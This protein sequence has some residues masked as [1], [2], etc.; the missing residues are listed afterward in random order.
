MTGEAEAQFREVGGDADGGPPRRIAVRHIR[1]AAAGAPGLFWLS[2]FKSDMASTKATAVAAYAR[3]HGLA[4]TL[5]DYSGHGLSSGRFEDGTIGQ[6]LEEACAVFRDMTTGPQV[7]IGSSM[8]GHIALLLLRRLIAEHPDHARRLAALV[9]IAPA[10]D[11][12]E[13]LIWKGMGEAARR[14][15]MDKGI[16]YRPSDYGEPYAITR[17][18]IEDGRRHL[19]SGRPF[20]PGRPVYILQ[21]ARDPDVPLAHVEALVGFLRGGWA[22]LEVVADGEHRLSRPEDLARLFSLVGRA[23]ADARR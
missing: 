7:V 22:H 13:A 15:V 4:A 1:A 14:A 23:V 2:G 5:F 6:W 9:L 8:G 19:L 17:A 3:D 18:L 21:G 11:M 20:D 12:T 10:W 16:T